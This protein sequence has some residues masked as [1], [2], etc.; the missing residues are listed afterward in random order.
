LSES[1]AGTG[2]ALPLMSW[3]AARIA[4][5][6]SFLDANQQSRAERGANVAALEKRIQSG[7]ARRTPE[8]QRLCLLSVSHQ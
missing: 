8:Q 6:A 5:F 7:A 4:A 1:K 2:T 3:S